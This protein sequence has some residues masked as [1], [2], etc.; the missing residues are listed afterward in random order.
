MVGNILAA[1]VKHAGVPLVDLSTVEDR[2]RRADVL[3]SML[4]EA[5]VRQHAPGLLPLHQSARPLIDGL[6]HMYLG[7]V[8]LPTIPV[9]SPSKGE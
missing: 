3:A 7:G 8:K 1:V 9:A 6:I 4:V 2:R 5:G